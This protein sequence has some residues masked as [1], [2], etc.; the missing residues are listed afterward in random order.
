MPERKLEIARAVSEYQAASAAGPAVSWRQV[1]AAAPFR[2]ALMR[3]I[4][5]Q[6]S[7]LAPEERWRIYREELVMLLVVSRSGGHGE[8]HASVRA[9]K[10]QIDR[11]LARATA[12]FATIPMVALF[13]AALG[14]GNLMMANVTSRTR[15]IA[16]MRAIGTTK[17][18]IAR[19]VVGEALVLGALGSLI[20][21]AVGM[22]AAASMNT[23]TRAI[24]GFE[25]VYTLDWLWIGLGVGLTVG[26]C[27]IAGSIPA[28]RAARNNI[29]DALQ[30]T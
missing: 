13:V 4:V 18:Q 5:P 24:W 27:L 12:L 17:S 22:H 29:I 21:I 10:T 26:V 8:Q 3:A 20:G 1:P 30:T 14:V 19:L 15:P 7:K 11:S 28:R 6:W 16:M 23:L 2:T 9:L 25:P